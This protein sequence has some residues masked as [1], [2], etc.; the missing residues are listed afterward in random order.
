LHWRIGMIAFKKLAKVQEKEQYDKA[1]ERFKTLDKGDQLKALFDPFGPTFIEE[2]S[3][4][5]FEDMPF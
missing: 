3:L 1:V 4:A 5:L 2:P